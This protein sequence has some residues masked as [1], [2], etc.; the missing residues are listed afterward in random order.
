MSTIVPEHRMSH[1]W[2]SD[3]RRVVALA[4]AIGLMFS[5]GCR[6]GP[7]SSAAAPTTRARA[8]ILLVTL[9]TTRADAVGPDATG[10]QT[11]AFNA[12]AAR[13]RRFRQAYAAVPETLPSH[14]SM[15]TGLYPGGHGIHEN[16][17][18]LPATFP[19]RRG[20]AAAGRLSDDGV[21]VV[22]LARAPVRP[23]ARVRSLRRR[24]AGWQ[25]RAERDRNDGPGARRAHPAIRSVAFHVGAL[26]RSSLSLRS[27][28]TVSNA[29]QAI[30]HI[31]AKWRPWTFR[32]DGWP[33]PSSSRRTGP[34]AIIVVA[35][36]GEGLGDHGESQHGNLLY[37]STMHV[38]LIVMAPGVDEQRQRRAGEHS[39]GIPHDSRS[40]QRSDLPTASSG[41]PEKSSL[42]KR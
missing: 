6:Q 19:G 23:R 29:I 37:Q 40:G 26:L 42:A 35:D 31:S 18:Y 14:T 2:S 4:L 11:P 39:P 27:A 38:P 30:I 41:R 25:C 24:A 15:M 16:A 9:D 28:R 32:S 5:T 10:V 13:G 22:V 3:R 21:R 20:A 12:L 1:L 36:H 34:I 8:S 17:R 7:S 33:R